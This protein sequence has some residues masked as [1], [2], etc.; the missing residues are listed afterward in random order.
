MAPRVRVFAGNL[1][2]GDGERVLDDASSHH[3]ARVLRLGR[4]DR[5][6]LFD[7]A[8]LEQDATILTVIARRRALEVCVALERSPRAGI[9]ADRARVH[10]LQGAPKHDKLERVVRACAE[11]GAAALWPIDCARSVAKLDPARA[12]AQ[13]AHLHAISISASEQSGR[14][15]LLRVEA[16]CSLEEALERAARTA[17][18]GAVADEEGGLPLR[19]WLASLGASRSPLA[20]LVGPEGGLDPREKSAAVAAGFERV[21]LGPRVLRTEHA[22]AAFCAV[23]SALR[24]DGSEP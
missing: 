7:G 13:R 1:A 22:A 24:G 6:V 12:E 3:V 18:V 4:G 8:G 17:L 14:A 23:A 19:R 21:S 2:L 20:V 15:D 16:V 9:V 10:V 11:L 5:L